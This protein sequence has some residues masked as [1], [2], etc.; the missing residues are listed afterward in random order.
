M[1]T[2]TF[3]CDKIDLLKT[4]IFGNRE[5]ERTMAVANFATVPVEGERQFPRPTAWQIQN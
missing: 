3:G 4:R 1:N 2:D 5:L